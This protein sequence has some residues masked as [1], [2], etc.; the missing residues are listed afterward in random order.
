MKA[1]L[2]VTCSLVYASLLV[3]VL[4]G[5]SAAATI[6]ES[7]IIGT[8]KQ[9]T[10][11]A[12]YEDNFVGVRFDIDTTW[13]V[14]TIGGHFIVWYG[15]GSIFGAVVQLD[16]FS[17]FPN[18]T[19]LSSS[20]VLGYALFTD[21]VYPSAEVSEP[22]QGDPLTLTPGVYA[23]IFGDDL[24]GT[25]GPGGAAPQH[26]T[27]I[28][29]PSYFRLTGETWYNGGFG[30]TR[31]F[32]TG[33]EVPIPPRSLASW[34]WPNRI[35]GIQKEVQKVISIQ[36]SNKQRRSQNSSAFRSKAIPWFTPNIMCGKHSQSL[37]A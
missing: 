26:N 29:S 21:T 24:W 33:S 28:D 22:L 35:C 27:E 14:D 25:T 6:Y 2:R 8:T 17:D 23:L 15:G 16:N 5:V 20:D 36:L 1:I 31:F 34:L 9:T 11:V 19:D 13:T 37:S 3:S 10:G 32:L 18:S 7:A 4:F 12:V 30:G